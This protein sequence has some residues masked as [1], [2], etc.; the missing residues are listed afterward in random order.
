MMKRISPQGAVPLLFAA[1]MAA[2]FAVA[3]PA[4][5]EEAEIIFLHVGIVPERLGGA[6]KDDAPA[7]RHIAMGG[8]ARSDVCIL[9]RKQKGHALFLVEAA[10]GLE[11]LR[12]QPRRRRRNSIFICYSDFHRGSAQTVQGRKRNERALLP[13]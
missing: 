11:Y 10:D 6:V 8:I 4:L 2:S 12:H 1:A 3:A 7:L 13:R 9:F 5:G